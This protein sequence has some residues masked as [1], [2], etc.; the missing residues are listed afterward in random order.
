VKQ[1]KLLP[2][3]NLTML[4]Y[5]NSAHAGL[6]VAEDRSLMTNLS[7]RLALEHPAAMPLGEEVEIVYDAQGLCRRSISSIGNLLLRPSIVVVIEIGK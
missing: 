7:F 2:H 4:C 5:H 1:E 6:F 3:G